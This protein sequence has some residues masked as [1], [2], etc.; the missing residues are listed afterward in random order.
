MSL[1]GDRPEQRSGSGS[2]TWVDVDCGMARDGLGC[3]ARQGSQPSLDPFGYSVQ[4]RSPALHLSFAITLVT[5]I[6]GTTN[7]GRA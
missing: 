2:K 5:S 7:D 6:L 3:A 1:T 4:R